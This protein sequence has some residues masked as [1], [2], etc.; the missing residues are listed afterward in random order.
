MTIC[1]IFDGRLGLFAL[2]AHGLENAC[3]SANL[4]QM[5]DMGGDGVTDSR[6]NEAGVGAELLARW[7]RQLASSSG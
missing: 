4:L 7:M 1:T 5:G 6:A 2:R 3:M